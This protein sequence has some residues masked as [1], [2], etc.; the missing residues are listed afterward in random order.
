MKN[1]FDSA[2]GFDQPIA[3]LRHCHDRIRKQLHTMQKLVEHLP[4]SG[5]DIEAQQAASAVI[6]Y[7][8]N[9]AGKHHEDEEQDLMPMLQACAREADADL[10]NS[11]IPG[12]LREHA[13]MESDWK[14]LHGQ[15]TSIAEGSSTA[16]S[17]DDVS[18]FT[19]LYTAHM[20][21]EESHIAPMAKRLFDDAQ[22][23]RLGEA[24]RLRRNIAA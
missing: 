24:M 14:R 5:A 22:M 12:L 21:K 1:L 6:R 9:A 18:R 17:A 15:L 19:A 23:A 2:P 3:V 8:E 4:T 7:F 16:L 11:L 10:L 13:Q 20:E